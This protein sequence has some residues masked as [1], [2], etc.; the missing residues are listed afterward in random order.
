[1][2][3]KDFL[4]EKGFIQD[5]TPSTIP[6]ETG[7]NAEK[8]AS[9]QNV[10]PT[11]F[12]PLPASNAENSTTGEPSF[13]APL[14]QERTT[15]ETPLPVQIDPSFI[16]YFEDELLKE[17]LPGPD[18][19]EFRQMLSKMQERMAAKGISQPEVVLQAVL[20]SFEAQNISSGK[21]V[22]TARIYK[23]GL[24]KKKNEFLLGA[25]AEKNNQLQKRQNVLQDHN[26]NI[27]KLEDQLSQL[28]LQQQ[29]LEELLNKERTQ[30][31]VDKSLGQEGIA[32]IEK[33]ERLI[34]L[35]HDYIQTTIDDDIKRLQSV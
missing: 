30:L 28:K 13:V 10:V 23:N 9:S 29:K 7:N 25:D 4:K 3:L 31:E 16:K 6:Q 34:S 20:T 26:D 1:M 8:K 19:F 22:E 14:V 32:K 5:D 35:A 15:Q 18:Y 11:T 27:R 12:F 21:L 33:A 24:E 17:N 2:G